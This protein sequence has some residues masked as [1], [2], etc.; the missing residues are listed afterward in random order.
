MP[1]RAM[2]RSAPELQAPISSRAFPPRGTV[3]AFDYGLR[4]VGV[5]IGELETRNAHPLAV[6]RAEGTARHAEIDRL[7]E[8]WKP[9]A[10]VVGVPQRDDGAHPLGARATRFARQLAARFR[11]P[12]ACVDESYSSVEAESRLR[13][14]AGAR[15]SARA[16]RSRTLDAHA[17]Q[18]LLEQYFAEAAS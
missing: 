8:E 10:L 4:R 17:A 3:L 1:E 12:V 2:P 18:L 9:G 5:A 6:I 14:A 7:I 15:R 11:L 16:S 13:V